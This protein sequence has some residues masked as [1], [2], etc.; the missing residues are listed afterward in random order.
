M[1]AS[2]VASVG[3]I[4]AGVGYD[5]LTKDVATS[6]HDYY[7]GHGE[8]PG[9]WSGRGIGALGLSGEV[10]ADDMAHL[11][12]RFV[13]PRTAGTDHEEVL[14]RK[15]STRT[16]HAGT[17]REKI[18]EPVAAFDVT[19]S[20]SKS[21]SAL[22]A[23]ATDEAVREIVI[24]AHERAVAAG[25]EY[26]EDNAGH[27]RAGKGGV[28]R[29]GTDGFIIAQFRH[30]TARATGAATVG[31]PQLHTHC[32]I[33]N[34]LHSED[35]R[36]RTLDSSAIYRHT[37]A[38]GAL[39]GAVFEQQLTEA[40][41]V[42]WVAPEAGERLPMR[43]IDGMPSTVLRQWSSRR[44]QLM[45]TFDRLEDKFRRTEQ[46][47][48]TRTEVAEMKAEATLKSRLPEA[49]GQCESA[50]HVARRSRRR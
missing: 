14:G 3:R 49:T 20:P 48:P 47:S 38:A 7:A 50:R 2:M 9:V 27:A 18:L 1:M 11:Y 15:V 5:Y 28:R 39:Y 37:H 43:E 31:D 33:L 4:S 34:R 44:E 46:R 21:A 41:G 42:A 45:A 32:A 29:V 19:F 26:L 10:S 36:W 35:G 30:R 22:F 16:I 25:L 24:D 17:T 40:L 23:A 8:A 12:G 6:K 13:D